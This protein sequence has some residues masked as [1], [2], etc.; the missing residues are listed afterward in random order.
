ML[1]MKKIF[2]EAWKK[3][4]IGKFADFEKDVFLDKTEPLSNFFV[5]RMNQGTDHVI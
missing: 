4:K 5:V 1:N 3:K 2:S